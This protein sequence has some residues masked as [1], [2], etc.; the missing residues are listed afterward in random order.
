VYLIRWHQQKEVRSFCG[1]DDV[2]V[3]VEAP[4]AA[5]LELAV[6]CAAACLAEQCNTESLLTVFVEDGGSTSFPGTCRLIGWPRQVVV[7]QN[8]ALV[9]VNVPP[10]L[11]ATHLCVRVCG[12][13]GACVWCVQCVRVCGVCGA[14]VRCVR[15]VRACGVCGA[16][17]WCVRVV[18][19]VRVVRAVQ[20][21]RACTMEKN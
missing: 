9:P 15:C 5:Y 21:V 14:C 13:C 3:E 8:P 12:V 19:V 18:C 2:S 6:R 16:C 11:D 20:C 1:L 7:W 4:V 10:S 17:M